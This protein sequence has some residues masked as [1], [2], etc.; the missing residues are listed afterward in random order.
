MKRILL[1]AFMLIGGRLF[2]QEWKVVE[3]EGKSQPEI[4]SAIK[5]WIADYFKSAK[6][7]IQLDEPA[8]IMVKGVSIENDV[9]TVMG[10]SIPANYTMNFTLDFQ[11]KDDKFRYQTKNITLN[12]SGYTTTIEDMKKSNEE[13]KI[14]AKNMKGAAK[15]GYIAGIQ[16]ADTMINRFTNTLHNLDESIN[17]IPSLEKSETENW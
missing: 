14:A 13:N 9:I 12:T 5:V 3:W 4:R 1:L 7:V 6:D 17:N 10:N 2:A 11:I 8:R 16:M 15:K